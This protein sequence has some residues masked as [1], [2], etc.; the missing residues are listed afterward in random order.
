LEKGN[1][2]GFIPN[3]SEKTESSEWIQ[4]VSAIFPGGEK[5]R[6]NHFS[7]ITFPERVR[8]F[9]QWT[10]LNYGEK[11]V[12]VT[13]IW[14]WNILRNKSRYDRHALIGNREAK[15]VFKLTKD[16]IQILDKALETD[17]DSTMNPT[18]DR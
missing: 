12:A 5:R 15:E 14:P 6:Q 17:S 13:G 7:C 3:H 9:I 18:H 11:K 16:M 2:I 4:P 10:K 8:R 1:G